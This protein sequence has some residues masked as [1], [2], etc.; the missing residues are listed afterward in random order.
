MIFKTIFFGMLVSFILTILIEP[1]II[2][3]M[4]R[5]KFGQAIRKDGPQTHQVKSGT[6]TM[7][8]IL[9]GIVTFISFILFFTLIN[10]DYI[11]TN[12]KTW[13]LLFLPL[14]GYGIIG[15][16]DD[17]LIVVKKT[18]DGLKPKMKFMLQ[19]VIAA[20]FFFI[21]V[22][23]GYSTEIYFTRYLVIDF[24]WFYGIVV[25]FMLVGGSN[26][27]NLTD[28]LDGLASGLSAFAIAT[29]TYVAYLTKQ[30]EIVIFGSALIG[31][32]LGFLVF[33]SHPAK[34]FM[35]D[36]GSLSL[37]AAISCMAILLKYELLLIIVGG[38]FVLETLS[39]IIQVA[40]FKKT[41][42]KRFFKMAPLHHHFELSGMK[43]S[44]VVLMFYAFGLLFSL[45]GIII[46]LLTL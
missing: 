36:T 12:Y 23:Q 31:T 30:Y 14:F 9:F 17:Y 37:G 3:Y 32:L 7:G 33:N 4:K 11:T 43:E 20:I 42:G 5:L 26:A 24:K 13:L 46:V 28:G 18:N 2:P 29:F 45:I 35:G 15:F 27:V 38:V 44:S 6:P 10:N 39:D 8:G 19:V 16:I 22:N 41:K 1:L 40:Y 34:I 21:Y 25:F